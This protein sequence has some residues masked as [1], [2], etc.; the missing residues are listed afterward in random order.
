M[1]TGARLPS[2]RREATSRAS[3]VVGLRLSAGERLEEAVYSERPRT[4]LSPAMLV[5][6]AEQLLGDE[7]QRLGQ[8]EVGGAD[9][10]MTRYPTP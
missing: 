8:A 7:E 4:K 10:G 1:S 9:Y 5:Q 3:S 2:Q 6:Q